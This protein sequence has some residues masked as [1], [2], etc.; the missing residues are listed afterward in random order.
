ME[1]TRVDVAAMRLNYTRQGLNE[2]EAAAEPLAQFAQ[3]FADACTADL[4]EPNAMVLATVD[5]AGAPRARV[6]LLKG[7]D[8]RGF[9]FYTNY[10]STK[11]RHLAQNHAAALNFHWAELERQV[12]IEGSVSP[13][14]QGESLAYFHSRP[15]E[16]QLGAWVSAQSQVISDRDILVRREEEFAAQYLD[17]PIPLPPHWGGYRLQP[18]SVEFWQGRPSRLHDRLRYRRNPSGQW[19]R[20]RLSP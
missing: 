15:R 4:R 8:E 16:S 3:W 7:Y 19:Q 18:D 6:V 1:S 12:C 9:V 17:Q 11:G 14:S 5:P 13:I 20:E 2:E 10:E